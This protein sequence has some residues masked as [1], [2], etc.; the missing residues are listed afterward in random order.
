MDYRVGVETSTESAVRAA[1]DVRVV[2]SR[3]RRRLREVAARQD[4]TPSQTSVLSV[5]VREGARSASELA[6]AERVRPQSMAA[7]LAVLEDAGL[8]HR[9]PDPADGRRLLV[10]L[11]TAGRERV[12]GDRAAREEWLARALR[13]RFTEDERQTV[14][15]AMRLLE[16]LVRP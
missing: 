2:F 11:T 9:S 4:L 3:L 8:I 5:L 16:R 7:T 10:T 13:E 15:S 14:I 12:E 6:A 1:R